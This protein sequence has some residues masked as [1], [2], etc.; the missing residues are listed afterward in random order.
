MKYITPP[1]VD[2]EALVEEFRQSIKS[3]TNNQTIE[4]KKS[5]TDLK[6]D[7]T[8]VEK[9]VIYLSMEAWIKMQDL[10]QSCSEEIAWHATVEKVPYADNKDKWY[11]FVKQV[12]VYP[13]QVTGTFVDVDPVKWT[14][15][16]LQLPDEVFSKIRFQGHSHVNMATSPSATD[17]ATYQN[18]LDQLGKDDYYIFMILNKRNEFN[19]FVYDFAQ[20]IIFDTKDCYVDVLL[21]N[22]SSLAKWTT[23]NMKQVAK[24]PATTTS[25]PGSYR[26]SYYDDEEY[27]ADVGTTVKTYIDGVTYA[28]NAYYV[29]NGHWIYFQND[30][31]KAY[32][33]L[34]HKEFVTEYVPTIAVRKIMQQLVEDGKVDEKGNLIPTN[35]LNNSSKRGKGKLP[36]KNN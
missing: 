28:N 8:K 9:P 1:E 15:W 31:E 6:I 27:L 2:V 32:F 5:F 24:K 12:Y 20:N 16:S 21:S 26:N 19:I 14:E 29:R 11:Y 3:R 13:Q 4:F 25:Y 36:K 7:E 22:G 33:F 23:E 30:R 18:L 34:K 10:V 17:Q 35:M